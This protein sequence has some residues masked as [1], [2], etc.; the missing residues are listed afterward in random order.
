MIVSLAGKTAIVTGAA[1]GIGL[2]IAR[3]FIASNVSGLVLVDVADQAPA[4]VAELVASVPEKVVYV[5]GDVRDE[6]TSER[7]VLAAIERFGRIDVLVNNAGVNVASPIHEQKSDDWD[8]VL[9]TNVKGLYFAACHVLPVMMRQRGGAIL[10]AGSISGLVGIAKQGAYGPSKGAVH[11]MTRQMAIEYA[12]YGIRV[13]AVAL[14]TI[15]TPILRKSA[16]QASMTY[17]DFVGGL[18]RMHPIGRIAS[19]EEAAKFYTYLASDDA[20]FITGAILS[21]DGGFT[22]H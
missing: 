7:F 18:E 3:Q 19:A 16:E 12:P 6:S 5:G 10:N 4:P 13:N 15:D 1:S 14:G 21:F 8:L 11:Q 2:A 17:E 22:A 9:D 20:S